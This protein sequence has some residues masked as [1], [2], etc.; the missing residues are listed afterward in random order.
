MSRTGI[1][2]PNTSDEGSSHHASNPSSVPA[3]ARLETNHERVSVWLH[4]RRNVVMVGT[5]GAHGTGGRD[6][7]NVGHLRSGGG[8]G[9]NSSS[10]NRKRCALMVAAMAA[11]TGC[12]D[13][14]AIPAHDGVV[15]DLPVLQVVLG[16]FD[17]NS[18]SFHTLQPEDRLDPRTLELV[19]SEVASTASALV[20]LDSYGCTGAACTG[21]DY[22]A[23]SNVPDTRRVIVNGAA[24][25]GD[26]LWTAADALNCGSPPT[27]GVCQGIRMRN[28]YTTQLERVYASLIELA[29]SGDTTA[30]TVPLQPW[31]AAADFGAAATFPNG[32]WRAGTIG[33]SSPETSGVTMHWAFNGETPDGSRLNFRFLVQVRGQIVH[34]TRRATVVGVDDPTA[35]YPPL[36]SGSVVTGNIDI[37]P[38]GRFVVFASSDPTLTGQVGRY[39]VRHDMETGENLV[40]NMLDGTATVVAGCSSNNPSI[41]ADG[42]LVAFENENCRLSSLPGV[43]SNLHIYVRNIA[44]QSTILVTTN[45]SG[46]YANGNSLFP[47]I[48]QNGNTVVFQSNATTLISGFPATT[49][50]RTIACSEIYRRDLSTGVTTHVSA[51]DGTTLNDVAGFAP[52]CS[53]VKETPAG[54]N[55]DISADG[56]TIVF[57]GKAPLE[58]SDTNG[59][60]DVYVYVHNGATA[61]VYRVSLSAA[62]AQVASPTNFGR[63]AVSPDGNV[64]AFSS[65][66]AGIVGAGNGLRHVYRR[67]SLR[68]ANTSVRRVTVAPGGALGVGGDGGTPYPV[69]SQTGRFVGFFSTFTNLATPYSSG[70]GENFFACDTEATTPDLQRCFVANVVELS[71][72][73]GFTRVAGGTGSGV[74]PGMACPNENS[75]C[76]V[77]YIKSGSAPLANGARQVWVSPIGDPRFQM[78]RPS[79]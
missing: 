59:D 70:S 1:S 57:L 67:S 19:P 56:S 8:N 77:A 60:S 44:S 28:L 39:I 49:A 30:V 78:P 31:G 33:R 38:N 46:G 23:F 20:D 4:R 71:P 61:D 17:G 13:Q 15:E 6:V 47:R 41:S 75:P 36:P 27:T 51:I 52:I 79:R 74:R 72:G 43:G 14:A 2:E 10:G 55:A 35:D 66:A 9:M 58:A 34:G 45:T 40:L 64:V 12:G 42:N 69:L 24:Q 53:G 16:H 54:H 37:T 68:G 5:L 48:S 63:P 29:P 65:P 73:A 62:G 3:Y 26:A 50:T 11:A 22:V 7:Q 18:F 21:D 32:M 76:Y 25:D